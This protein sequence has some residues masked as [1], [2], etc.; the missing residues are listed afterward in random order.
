MG[1][2]I[3]RNV[4]LWLVLAVLFLSMA[5]FGLTLPA[6]PFFV[7]RLALG[8]G[9]SDAQ[10]TFH[11]GLLTSVYA[12][13]QVVF[14]PLFGAGSDRWGRKPFL[15]VG[16][17]GF[18]A[19][20]GVFGL[21]TSLG[22][23]YLARL[24][25]GASASA[26][27]TVG[28]A[29]VADLVEERDRLRAMAWRGMAVS[30]GVVVGPAMSGL[31][32][33]G[34]MHGHRMIGHLM[35]DGFSIPFLTAGAIALL[36]TPLVMLGLRESTTPASPDEAMDKPMPSILDL[37]VLS[38]VAQLALASFEAVF[39][40]Y[41]RNVLTLDLSQIGWGFVVC[42]GVMAGLQAFVGVGERVAARGQMGAGFV[43]LGAGLLTLG[44]SRS[45]FSTFASIAVLAGGMAI[46]APNLA[47]A[48]TDRRPH[49]PGA[50]LGLQNTALG[51]GQVAGP[52]VGTALF[53]VNV[54]LPFVAMAL[55]C[56]TVGVS[57]WVTR[58]RR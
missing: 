25:A 17:V 1:T 54:R 8:P 52:L 30:L 23:L 48:V 18:A 57:A 7:E 37:L 44:F 21:A 10:I 35:L 49:A 53:T 11:V 12:L 26:L 41:A 50:S 43:A 5:G 51:V 20:Q 15:L 28:S 34:D 31:L 24:A 58:P 36:A 56:L 32:S 19:A 33:R 29:A 13:S 2:A 6:L 45:L 38:A 22:P 46:L 47:A 3:V 39:A 4:Q 9:A 55:V 42:G 16:L 40:L 27:F 14:G